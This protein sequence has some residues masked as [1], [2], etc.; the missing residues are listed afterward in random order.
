M[1][2]FSDNP[3]HLCIV[4]C[5]SPVS[6]NPEN[7]E[8]ALATLPNVAEYASRHGY[9]LEVICQ[10]F[11]LFR[12]W[13]D[14]LADALARYEH[15]FWMGSDVLITNPD[16]KLES[17][18]VPGKARVAAY[19]GAVKGIPLNADTILL[20]RNPDGM[21]VLQAWDDCKARFEQSPLYV[22]DALT[23]LALESPWKDH[24]AI[25][26]PRAMQSHPWPG[27]PTMWQPGDFSLHFNCLTGGSPAKVK[28]V[29]AMLAT[30]DPLAVSK[31]R[32]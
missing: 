26:P 1:K 20:S 24:I 28:A 14:H 7:A 21:R 19:E 17:F 30:G 3:R 10:P 8:L 16:I 29:R 6:V 11:P 23:W 9:D 31:A 18:L 25:A 27:F 22:Q 5:N 12:W 32:A 4:R 13:F 2:T 15:V